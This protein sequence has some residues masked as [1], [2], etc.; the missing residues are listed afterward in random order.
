MESFCNGAFLEEEEEEEEEVL[1]NV[2]LPRN[3][4]TLL[5]TLLS[6]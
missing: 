1:A 5:W 3:Q 6:S 4:V 2:L